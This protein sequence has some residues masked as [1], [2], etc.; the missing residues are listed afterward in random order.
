[1]ET[2]Y[3]T[4]ANA[5]PSAASQRAQPLGDRQRQKHQLLPTDTAPGVAQ[6]V[7]QKAR[8]LWAADRVACR[9]AR[10]VSLVRDG[11]QPKDAEMVLAAL[12]TFKHAV[13]DADERVA[14]ARSR[15]AEEVKRR[16][17]AVEAQRV[18]ADAKIEGFAAHRKAARESRTSLQR[19]REKARIQRA[20][21]ILEAKRDAE[22][23]RR[24]RM[25]EE[26][27]DKEWE[28]E[29]QH[30][31][32]ARQREVQRRQS[33]HSLQDREAAELEELDAQ[34]RTR[35]IVRLEKEQGL[36]EAADPQVIKAMSGHPAKL[37][38]HTKSIAPYATQLRD[39]GYRLSRWQHA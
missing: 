14:L 33:A 7:A 35:T 39:H 28:K 2:D 15:K 8:M 30:V 37:G 34:R 29:Q 4:R 20:E 16:R 5:N 19:E 13:H 21:S 32:S 11:K 1:M 10:A 22:V 36:R 31:H 9:L 6:D 23:Q 25:V 3:N 12:E 38:G 18:A 17:D 26:L 27:V 24:T